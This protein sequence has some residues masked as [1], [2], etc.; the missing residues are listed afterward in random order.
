MKDEKH[1][2]TRKSLP[3]PRQASSC[4]PAGV[5]L[6]VH[7]SRRAKPPCCRRGFVPCVPR[8]F[9]TRYRWV[10]GSSTASIL[11]VQY[12]YLHRVILSHYRL[13]F[14]QTIHRHHTKG[15]NRTE[16][17]S[18]P[19]Q[20]DEACRCTMAL[21]WESW[22]SPWSRS[23]GIATPSLPSPRT[24]WDSAR[25]PWGNYSSKLDYWRHVRWCVGGFKTVV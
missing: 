13:L 9:L 22:C 15:P 24:P 19:A 8:G 5:G 23:R 18:L 6:H 3:G 14:G 7:S 17:P 10:S 21:P 1:R 4:H 25:T 16:P 12:S 20:P 2:K 11:G